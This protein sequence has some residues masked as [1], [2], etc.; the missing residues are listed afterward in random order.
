M[1]TQDQNVEG[2]LEVTQR[3]HVVSSEGS[4]LE[5]ESLVS[6]KVGVGKGH[7]LEHVSQRFS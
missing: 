4:Q 1:G 2:G 5:E 3:Y 6:P 7:Q